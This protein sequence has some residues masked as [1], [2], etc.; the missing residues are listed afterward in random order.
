MAQVLRYIIILKAQVF[1][2][3]HAKE[4]TFPIT[5][6]YP[7]K[8]KRTQEKERKQPKKKNPKQKAN[9]LKE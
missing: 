2:A 1:S 3:L 6:R 7:G 4:E 8:A 5:T 9:P